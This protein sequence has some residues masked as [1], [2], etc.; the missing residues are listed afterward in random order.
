MTWLQLASVVGSLIVIRISVVSIYRDLQRDGRR[1][2][3]TFMFPPAA[4]PSVTAPR[5]A[6]ASDAVS[7]EQS[8]VERAEA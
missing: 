8:S 5:Q 6:E 2:L 7:S 4:P 1:A 3:Q